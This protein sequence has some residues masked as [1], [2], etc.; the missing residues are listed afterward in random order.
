MNHHVPRQFAGCGD[1]FGLVDEAETEM[2]GPI[3][4]L[5]PNQNATSSDSRTTMESVAGAGIS[6]LLSANSDRRN[7]AIPLSTFN[8]VR[9]PGKD[10]PRSTSVM[11]TEGCIPTTTVSASRMRDIAAMLLSMRPMKESTIST[12]EMSIRTPRLRFLT[13]RW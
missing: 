9:T 13:M 12:E 7:N 4:D 5:M 3:P 11:A 8:A 10:R 2:D 6:D 1:H